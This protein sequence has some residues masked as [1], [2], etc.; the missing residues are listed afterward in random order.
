M[1]AVFPIRK[2][3]KKGDILLPLLFRFSLEPGFGRYEV[4]RII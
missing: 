3:M 2:A 1:F 4:N